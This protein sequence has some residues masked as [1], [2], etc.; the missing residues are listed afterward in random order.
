MP[1]PFPRSVARLD[2][3]TPRLQTALLGC[4]VLL[5][6]AWSLW[7]FRSTISVYA[8]SADARLEVDGA[9]YPVETPVAG[10]VVATSLTMGQAVEAGDTLVS[11]D[12]RAQD[13]GVNEERARLS[14]LGPQLSR[15]EAE[16]LEQ[17]HGRRDESATSAA[18]KAEAEASYSQA[19]AAADL[20]L[21]Q[22][23]RML[24]LAATGLLSQSELT[25]AQSETKQRRAAAEALRL[26]SVRIDAEQQRKDTAHRIEL[27]KLQREAAALRAQIGTGTAAVKRLENEGALRRIVAPVSGTLAEVSPL[28]VGG[29]LQVGDT[30]ATIMPP[31]ALRVVAGFLP[32]EA[33]GRVQSGQSARLRL[34]GF[35]ATQY[36]MLNATVSRVASEVRDGRVRVELSLEPGNGT[37]PLQHGL[38]GVV[39]VEIA[40]LSPASLVLRAVG[41]RLGPLS[42]TNQSSSAR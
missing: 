42:R 17:E 41:Q 35:P 15:V 40:Q 8:V 2:R 13:F 21:D 23:Q 37:V 26:T 30:V 1:N 33:F 32:A 16:I 9:T 4:A 14:G 38:P 28:R 18:A 19:V 25:R 24:K 29:V 27:E 7:F 31:G 22:E 20:A 11:L 36:G 39:E 12:V 6:V 5:L 34:E 10:R 3:E